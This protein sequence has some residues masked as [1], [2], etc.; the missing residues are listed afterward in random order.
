[1]AITKSPKNYGSTK[2]HEKDSDSKSV[3]N[4]DSKNDGDLEER[5]LIPSSE[6]DSG[7]FSWKKLWLFT[8]PGWL[9]NQFYLARAEIQKYY[10]SIWVQMK[11]LN[12]VFEIY[13][14]LVNI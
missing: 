7:L 3:S 2:N 6:D 5:I 1:M 14:P 8:G 12:F 10:R 13:W 4:D 9:S 11:T